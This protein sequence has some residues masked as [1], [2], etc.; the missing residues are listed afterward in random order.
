MP[1]P[2]KCA[3]LAIRLQFL[4]ASVFE[5]IFPSFLFRKTHSYITGVLVVHRFEIDIK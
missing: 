2:G 3:A 1:R 5:R 4:Q